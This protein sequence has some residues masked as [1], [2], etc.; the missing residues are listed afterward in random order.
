LYKVSSIS[1]N[2]N[3]I[4]RFILSTYWLNLYKI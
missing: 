1:D 4:S 3:I 2:F